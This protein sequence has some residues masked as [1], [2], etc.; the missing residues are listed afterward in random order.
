MLPRTPGEETVKFD[1]LRFRDR[2]RGYLT[3]DYRINLNRK[4]TDLLTASVELQQ[5]EIDFRMGEGVLLF[6]W[7]RVMGCAPLR[8]ATNRRAACHK[9]LP[10]EVSITFTIW[11]FDL[12]SSL[13]PK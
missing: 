4:T 8:A 10:R 12:P 6:V 2:T 5:P 13:Q 9:L 3:E 11:F 7:Q 1:R